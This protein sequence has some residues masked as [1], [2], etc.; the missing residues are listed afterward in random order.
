[1]YQFPIVRNSLADT[2]AKL[3]LERFLLSEVE[4]LVLKAVEA[5]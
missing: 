2:I 3:H 4:R 1:M 5:I